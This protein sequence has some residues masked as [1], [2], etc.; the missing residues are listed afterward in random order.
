M[1]EKVPPFAEC[2]DYLKSNTDVLKVVLDFVHIHTIS[3][4]PNFECT[5]PFPLPE[6]ASEIMTSPE[7]SIGS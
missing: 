4:D 2:L 6:I 3:Q 1:Y 7:M 5:S